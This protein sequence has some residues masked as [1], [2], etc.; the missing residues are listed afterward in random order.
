MIVDLEQKW[1]HEVDLPCTRCDPELFFTDHGTENLR[2]PSNKIQ[3][4]WNRAKVVC[5]TCPVKRQCARDNLGELD[6]VVGGLDPAQR[7]VLR[8]T[9]DQNVRRLSGSL[10]VE[11][12]ALAHTLRRERKLAFADIGRIMGLPYTTAQYLVEWYDRWLER[13]KPKEEIKETAEDI[14]T[15]SPIKVTFP[16]NPPREGDTWV[17]YDRHVLRGYYLGQTEDDAWYCIKVKLLA[18]EYSVCW[19]MADD[20]KIAKPVTRNVLARSGASGSR[21]YGNKH[22]ASGRQH[23]EAG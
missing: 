16:D 15:V 8:K 13:T 5:E 1:R 12:A 17:R 10:K 21:I 2:N 11:Y 7:A 23:A 14:A 9:H 6:G 22:T 19:L 20:V 18:S 3:A 4:A